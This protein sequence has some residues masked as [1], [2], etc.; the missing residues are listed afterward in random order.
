MKIVVCPVC[1]ETLTVLEQ[2]KEQMIA[3]NNAKWRGKMLKMVDGYIDYCKGAPD[4]TDYKKFLFNTLD[5][6][7]ES[8]LSEMEVKQ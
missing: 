1:G 8:I 4:D 5:N 3:A 6:I 7:K 2:S